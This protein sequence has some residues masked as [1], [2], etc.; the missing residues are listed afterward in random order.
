MDVGSQGPDRCQGMEV[1]TMRDYRAMERKAVV[2]P[3]I[4]GILFPNNQIRIRVSQ[5]AR[6]SVRRAQALGAV[7]LAY[8]I[9]VK[10]E[11][12]KIIPADL[13]EVGVLAGIQDVS[14]HGPELELTLTGLARVRTLGIV[15]EGA[16]WM[17]EFDFF[18]RQHDVDPATEQALVASILQ[19]SNE[20]LDLMEARGPVRSILNSYTRAEPLMDL[21][22][23]HLPLGL[24]EKQALLE[25]NG[26]K[27]LAL[28]LLDLLAKQ[29]ESLKLQKELA[30]RISEQAG[31]THRENLLRE[32]LKAIQDQL[33]EGRGDRKD[34]RARLE[35]A[36]L[37][38]PVLEEAL[39]E[40]E[41]M[42]AMGPHNPEASV[43]RNW[44]DLILSLPWRDPEPS[45]VDLETARRIL[46]E[47]H[48][49]LEK[50]KQRILQYLAVLELK[51]EK[52][53]AL[54][55]L[56]GPPGVG[57]TS[58]GRS[59]ARATG[60][61]FV[62]ASLGGVRDEADIRG[63][64]RTYVGAMPGRILR[65]LQRVK[66]KNPVFVLDEVDKL[67]RGWAGDPAAALLE[68]LDP[69]Q[70]HQFVDH[71][72]DLP[73]DLSQVFFVAT[74]NSVDTI[75]Q[76]LLD[77]MEVISLPG[78]TEREKYEIAVRH[79]WPR[80]LAE[81]GLNETDLRLEEGVVD[82]VIHRYTREAGVR[83]LQRQLSA[84]VRVSA[85]KVLERRQGGALPLSI[86]A[87]DL[88]ELLGREQW[89]ADEVPLSLP[90]GVAVGL[91]WTPVGGEVLLV[92]AASLEG[93]GKVVLTGHLGEVMK[94]SAKLALSLVRLLVPF[95]MEAAAWRHTNWHIHVPAGAIPK[96]GPSAG[97]AILAALASLVTRRAID[98]R[99]AMTGEITLRGAVLPVGGIKEKVLAA[100][101]AGMKKVILPARNEPDWKE[102]PADVR[103]TLEVVFVDRVSQVLKGALGLEV[104]DWSQAAGEG[105]GLRAP[106][107]SNA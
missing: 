72:L 89:R 4:G 103:D 61:E 45:R 68:V 28:R 56:V 27:E 84:L 37:P 73:F 29:R 3:L 106:G 96:D 94:E 81:H 44:L 64:R 107:L 11:K 41:R 1:W 21:V 76:P 85:P 38:Q 32:Q 13:P 12:G 22:L 69:E 63:H 42:E 39:E 43:I 51:P 18:D 74:A 50:V 35:Q 100:H 49:G 78:Y 16:F 88:S 20:I 83:E 52:K 86:R 95:A 60:R 33:H 15:D 104:P 26:I 102:V 67:G 2:L 58:L 75:P 93:T 87:E 66:T 17:A 90:P 105:D 31:K 14:D 30:R 6:E 71:F 34:Y 77:R 59:I 98:P 19:V 7:G 80:A 101:R 99:V 46:D 57:K 40:L 91:A 23:Q 8:A 24:A 53:G 48:Y 47:D 82:T 54:L 25:V 65:A 62:R 79:L 92:E 55:L 97:V 70:N 36:G 9:E 10:G 5:E